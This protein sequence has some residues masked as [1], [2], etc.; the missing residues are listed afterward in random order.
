MAVPTANILHQETIQRL[1]GDGAFERG[2]SYFQDGR[3]SEL[4]RKEG[5]VHA[6]VQGTEAYAVRIWT[7][8]ESLAY[9]CSCP[10]GQSQA[11]CKHAVAVALASVGVEPSEPATSA[12]SPPPPPFPP[13]R[14]KD[15]PEAPVPS[16]PSVPRKGSIADSLRSLS[17]DE[18]LLIVLEA[19]LDDD[20][21]RDRIIEKLRRRSD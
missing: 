20:A 17:R 15:R 12:P 11:F 4:Q 19:A 10:Q 16:A 14:P 18:L 9:A 8:D 13:A 3:V 7:K 21:F 2:R 6:R 1:S 5:A